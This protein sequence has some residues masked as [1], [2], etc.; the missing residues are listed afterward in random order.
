DAET[1]PVMGVSSVR[2]W[3]A[4]AVRTCAYHD[5]WPFPPWSAGTQFTLPRFVIFSFEVDPAGPQQRADYAQRLLEPVNAMVK[6]IS[7]SAKLRL[8]PTSPQAKDQAATADL[9]ESVGHSGQKRPIAKACANH[10]ASNLNARGN[11]RQCTEY[12]PTF[13]LAISCVRPIN[14][15]MIRHPD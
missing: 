4:G 3:A 13:P 14:D 10:K 12:R 1:I 11:C 5:R 8:V 7:E 15:Q 9:I 6:R 2:P